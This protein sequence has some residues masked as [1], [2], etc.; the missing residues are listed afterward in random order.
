L[1]EGRLTLKRLRVVDAFGRTLDVPVDTIRVPARDE[2]DGAPAVLR[3]RPRLLRPARWMF[4]LVDPADHSTSSREANVDQV[5]PANMVN[6]VAG[7]L[8]PDH[9]DEA[10]EFFD[11]AGAPLG[12]LMHEPF[13]GGVMW[14]IA[15][16]RAGPARSEEHTSELQSRENLVCRLL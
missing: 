9:I 15:P 2:I 6:P 10:L 11:T 5:T 14:E 16:G 12:Q 13:G 8:L 1:A 7:F 3:L 4:R